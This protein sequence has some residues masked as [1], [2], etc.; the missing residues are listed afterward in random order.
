VG[1]C[2][3]HT[4]RILPMDPVGVAVTIRICIRDYPVRIPGGALTVLPEVFRGF[5]QFFEANTGMVP[6]LDYDRLLPSCFH[7]P[8]HHSYHL[9]IFLGPYK[10]PPRYLI[11]YC[12]KVDLGT[13]SKTK[14]KAKLRGF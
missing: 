9:V 14:K 1:Q 3:S 10:Q 6:R 12:P 11:I 13:S 2:G 4:V 5:L 8:I 7:F